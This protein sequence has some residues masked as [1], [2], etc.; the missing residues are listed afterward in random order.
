[1]TFLSYSTPPKLDHSKYAAM[2]WPRY[3]W[4]KIKLMRL[5]FVLPFEIL[6]SPLVARSK[7]KSF[8]RVVGDTLFRFVTDTL[9]DVELQYFLGTSVGIY[10]EWARKEKL[11]ITI[12]ELQ[13]EG[14]LLWIGPKR[15]EKVI[16]FCHGG[17]Y[18]AP[19]QNFMLPF[20]RFIQLELERRGLEVGIAIMSYSVIPVAHFPIPLWQANQ[21]I[22]HLTYV[23]NVKPSNLQLVGDSAGGNLVSQIL[24]SMLHP[25]FSPPIIPPGTRLR[26]AYMMSPWISMTGA[27]SQ[28]SNE[29]LPSFIENDHTDVLSTDSLVRWGSDVL[30]GLQNP[31]FDVPFVDPI[32]APSDWYKG[33]SDVVERVFVSTGEFECLRDADRVFFKEKIQ[34]WHGKAEFFELKGGVHNDPFFDF[35]VGDRPLGARQKLTP[36]VLDW[37][38]NGFEDDKGEEN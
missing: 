25:P 33:L 23:E 38:A 21:A 31:F 37:V 20:W 2:G 35:Y 8:K 29:I 9:P 13:G 10:S 17:A 12:D 19:L 3:L 4:M 22:K 16:L 5:L 18:I 27:G 11:P 30:S 34:P 1:M 28:E 15:T 7:A 26:G 36:M 6:V 14:K 24:S 32:R